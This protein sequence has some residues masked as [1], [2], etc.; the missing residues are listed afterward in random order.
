MRVGLDVTPAVT[1]RAGLARYT[2][3]LWREL[4]LREDVDVHAFALGRGPNRDFGLPLTRRHLPLR[5]LRPLWR[6][7]RWPRAETF[8]GD[9]DVVHTIALTPIPTRSRQTVTIHD[10]L[11]ITHPQ[12]YPPGAD[13]GHRADLAE[14]QRAQ[15]LVTT[16]EAT[17]DEIV[18][19]AG[20]PRDR[21]VV[22]PPGVLRPNST[23]DISPVEPPFVLAVGQV[24]PRKGFDVIAEAAAR[25]GERCPPV[26]LAGP[27]WWR[28]DDVRAR[29]AEVDAHRRVRLL[30]PVD[31]STLSAL[32]RT[33]TVVLHASRA[34]GFGMTCLEAM[35]F[36]APVVATDLAPVRELSGGAVELVP[37]DDAAALAGA[38]GVLL[39]DAARRRELGNAARERAAEFTWSRMAAE[40]VDAYRL[41]LAA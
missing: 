6:T 3:Q 32:Y 37:V 10:L 17:A 16:C 22:A 15:V 11:P 24:T 41:A 36:G 2:E 39:E 19:V 29:I 40:V 12:L 18:R 23:G 27:D 25:L 38:L 21:I 13:R 5:A 28:A 7:V 20:F 8:A 30:G 31:D 9:V 14:A 26:V 1:A 33:A 34:E 4:V 35:A